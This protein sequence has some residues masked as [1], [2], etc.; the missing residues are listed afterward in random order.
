[1]KFTS[2]ALFRSRDIG[3]TSLKKAL[4]FLS[5]AATIKPDCFNFTKHPSIL[6]QQ[7]PLQDHDM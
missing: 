7:H 2:K 5:T 4:A 6:Q 3:P 1:M